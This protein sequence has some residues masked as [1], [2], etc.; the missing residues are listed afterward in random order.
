MR[1]FEINFEA[2]L[3]EQFP[4]FRD[5]IKASVY[6]CGRPFKAIAA[7]M[8]MSVSELSRKLADNPNDPVN[9]PV[10]RLP[11]LVGATGDRRP[12]YWL[13]EAFLEDP[14]HRRQHVLSKIEALLPELQALVKSATEQSPLSVAK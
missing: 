8:D 10:H 13:I 9:F 11:E 3:V 5:V 1:Q 2:G 4:E 7:D 6:S 14:A 12:I